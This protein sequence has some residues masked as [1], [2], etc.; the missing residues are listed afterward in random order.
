MRTPICHCGI[1]LTTVDEPLVFPS[2]QTFRINR[3]SVRP[4]YEG[5]KDGEVLRLVAGELPLFHGFTEIVMDSYPCF[6]VE[7]V[8]VIPPRTPYR[9]QVC[10][11]GK[12]QQRKVRVYL[13]GHYTRDVG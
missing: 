11:N 3:I 1:S 10:L 12:V 4:Q 9:V 2:D 7:P 13:H 8:I 5:H 6:L